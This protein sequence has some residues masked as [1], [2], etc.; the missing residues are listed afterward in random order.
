MCSHTTSSPVDFLWCSFV[1][2][3]HPLLFKSSLP[4]LLI[5]HKDL[6]FTSP[7]GF[8]VATGS[9]EWFIIENILKATLLRSP[10]SLSECMEAGPT[11]LLTSLIN[12]SRVCGLGEGTL[13]ISFHHTLLRCAPLKYR[14]SPLSSTIPRCPAHLRPAGPERSSSSLAKNNL[15]VFMEGADTNYPFLTRRN[16]CPTS[17]ELRILNYKHRDHFEA[18]VSHYA[19]IPICICIILGVVTT[20]SVD[21]LQ[22]FGNSHIFAPHTNS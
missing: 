4:C 3:P 18:Q 7:F 13:H 19:N 22:S 1:A 10:P 2:T 17:W 21:A 14:Y 8:W 11:S 12:L 5:H 20:K 6:L 16:V 15:C 9:S